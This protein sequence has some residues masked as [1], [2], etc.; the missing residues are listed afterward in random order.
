MG[1]DRRPAGAT[2]NSAVKG[3][4]SAVIAF[5]FPLVLCPRSER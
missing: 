4:M 3:E 5:I 2:K 1:D